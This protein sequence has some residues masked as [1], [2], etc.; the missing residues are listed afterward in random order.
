MFEVVDSDVENDA[1]DDEDDGSRSKRVANTKLTIERERERVRERERERERDVENETK[2]WVE[3]STRI[4]H[5]PFQ[6]SAAIKNFLQIKKTRSK[7]FRKMRAELVSE[8][9]L[10]FL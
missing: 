9:Q 5:F 8:T 2:F 10:Q 7:G 3:K 1:D 4:K 6:E